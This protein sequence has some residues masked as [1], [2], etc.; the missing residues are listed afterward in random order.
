[1]V[2]KNELK[3]KTGE[4]LKT[5]AGEIMYDFRLDTG[6]EFIPQH[7]SL[8]KSSHQAM[9]DGVKKTIVNYKLKV[10]V[11]GY[12]NQDPIFVSLT[13]SQANTFNKKISDNVILNQNLF[14]AYTYQDK[15]GND[16]VGV[17]FKPKNTTPK[18]FEELENP[19]EETKKEE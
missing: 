6:D 17:G 19:L 12:N 14:C 8:L 5:K 10:I 1:M 9:V 4:V 15:E 16:W 11:K 18:T 13:P 2:Q 7:N 3:T